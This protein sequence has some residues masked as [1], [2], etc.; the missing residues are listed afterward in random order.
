MNI[1]ELKDVSF[2]YSNNIKAVD[3]L[4][5]CIEKGEKIAIIGQNG[6]GKSTTVKMFNGLLRPTE[7][8]IYIDGENIKEKTTAMVSKKV[9][10]VFQNPDDQ[11]FNSTVYKEVEYGPLKLN[12]SKKEIEERVEYALN[13][14]KIYEYKD[15]NPYNLPLS[16]RK[17]VTIASVIAMNADV[18]IFDE[19]TA[20]QD[21][22]GNKNLEQILNVL[23]ES[24]KTTITITHDMEFV[25]K[26]FDKIIVMAN[27][28]IL[29]IGSPKEIFF[30]KKILDE[31]MIEQPIVSKIMT[32]LK[33]NEKIINVNEAK[34]KI[35]KLY[36]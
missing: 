26:N 5:L 29:K 13:L 6:A 15:E 10:Y 4:N 16:I 22:K 34:D 12:L 14:T 23:Q 28:K 27:K 35:L 24:G 33:I 7:G 21:L 11:I 2:S 1:I 31:A 9:G 20:G 25:V 3:N 17:F 8:E 19:P 32:M 30:D 36:L 18:Y